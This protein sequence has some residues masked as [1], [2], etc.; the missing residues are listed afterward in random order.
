[1]NSLT[2]PKPLSTKH[3]AWVIEWALE[4]CIEQMKKCE[5][6]I[7]RHKE[8]PGSMAHTKLGLKLR[9]DLIEDQSRWL[10]EYHD[11]YLFLLGAR[12]VVMTKSA[13]EF[14]LDVAALFGRKK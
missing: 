14:A 1:M 10:R 8:N 11:C 6:E 7:A 3:A 5:I 12:E 2:K 13:E 4:A 9:G